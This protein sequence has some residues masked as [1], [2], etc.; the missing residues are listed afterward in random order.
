MG[1]NDFMVEMLPELEDA[2]KESV[3]EDIPETYPGIRNMLAYHLGWEGEGSGTAAQGKRIRPII[4]LLSAAMYGA[5]WRKVLPA[6]VA[7][8][9]LHNFSLIHDD[10]E[11]ASETRRGRLTVWKIWGVPQA[12]NSGDAMFT[13]AHLNM[14]KLSGKIGLQ[15][16]MDS[17][18]LLNKTCVDLTGGQYLD[19][20]FEKRSDVNRDEYFTMIGGK[21]AS[22]I[23]TC[24]ELGA[25][26]SQTSMS[27][28]LAM[29]SYGEA[30][31]IAFQAWDDWLGIWG[32]EKIT[33][34]SN[35]SDL[36]AGKKS[37]PILFGLEKESRF[38]Q[39][40]NHFSVIPEEKI[41]ELVRFLE[42]EG[43]KTYTEKIA[44][45][46]SELAN[47]SLGSVEVNDQAAFG[48]L[49]ELTSTLL[50]RAK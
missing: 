20:S 41:P 12:I 13:L 15:V 42:D 38:A 30:L 17:A 36:K 45:H 6:A 5:D 28:Q 19:M 47:R 24:A 23:S 34:K 22:L 46:Y 11:D 10:I 37:L 40:Y 50:S 7:V 16:G 35:S 32:N 21:T 33:G 31:G 49:K 1:L 48:A 29:R 25:I 9:M 3:F 14:L 2:L 8:E 44:S 43:A 18:L 39:A 27:N 4:V 26:T